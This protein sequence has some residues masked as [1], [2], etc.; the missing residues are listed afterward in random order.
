MLLNDLTIT[1]IF[2]SSFITGFN[3]NV[4]FYVILENKLREKESHITKTAEARS[5]TL[6][7]KNSGKTAIPH[8]QRGFH[9]VGEKILGVR[10]IISVICH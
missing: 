10:N 2:F 6:R 3:A 9:V 7:N 8:A 5:A 1:I 4:C